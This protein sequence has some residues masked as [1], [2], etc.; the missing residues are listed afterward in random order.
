VNF[1]FIIV[2][3]CYGHNYALHL[4]RLVQVVAYLHLCLCKERI[5]QFSGI[6]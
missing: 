2:F 4:P 6:L 3:S 5:L 1:G